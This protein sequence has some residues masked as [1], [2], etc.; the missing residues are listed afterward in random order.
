MTITAIIHRQ[1]SGV[2]WMIKIR[3]D[4][5]GMLPVKSWNNN[6]VIPK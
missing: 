4:T 6:N 1:Y 3:R 2:N 5:A